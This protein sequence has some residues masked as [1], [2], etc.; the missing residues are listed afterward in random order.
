MV[1]LHGFT[2]TWRTWELVLPKLERH[3]DVLAP[4]LAGHAGGP[5][6]SA[7]PSERELVEAVE[8][9]MDE[10]GFERA[11]LVGNSLGGF[12]ALA[13][14][15]RGRALTVVALAPAGGWAPDDPLAEETNRY[16]AGMRDLVI[17]AAPHAEAIMATPEGRRRASEYTAVNYEHLSA[18][19]LAHQLR[20][21]A[22]CDGAPAL[23][24]RVRGGR[25]ELRAQDVTCP[26]RI[27]WG[28]EDRLLRWPTAAVRYRQEWLPHADWIELDGVGHCPQLDVPAVTAE[29]ILEFTAR[30]QISAA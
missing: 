4:T 30:D 9:A 24:E 16:F 25:F 20:G 7:D 6:L 19:L 14:A 5:E 26:V 1:C 3:H 22:A 29:L 13:L 27:V 23:L 28:R 10:A 11:H 15:A 2:D 8:R 12:L 21:A 17:A 18:E